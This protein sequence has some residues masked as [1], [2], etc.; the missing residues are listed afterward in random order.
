V[1]GIPEND[2]PRVIREDPK[3]RGLLYVGT[4]HGVYVS[5]NDGASWQSLR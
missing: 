4:E 3:R 5:F 2:F 1:N